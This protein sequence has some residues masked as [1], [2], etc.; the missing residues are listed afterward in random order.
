MGVLLLFLVFVFMLSAAASLHAAT[1]QGA[2][3]AT[4]GILCCILL[5]L[6]IVVAIFTPPSS[7]GGTLPPLLHLLSSLNPVWVL[8]PLDPT[9]GLEPGKA[10]G[11]FLLF[12]AIYG[13]A[14]SG[15]TGMMLWRFDRIMGR[16]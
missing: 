7:I 9:R 6:P 4:A 13:T 5:V 3:L 10:F 14:V 1:L 2:A 12:A 8:E 16:T 15:L 11:R